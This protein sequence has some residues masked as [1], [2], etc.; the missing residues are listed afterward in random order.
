M[1]DQGREDELVRDREESRNKDREVEW[2]QEQG[3]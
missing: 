1:W 3:G 2:D